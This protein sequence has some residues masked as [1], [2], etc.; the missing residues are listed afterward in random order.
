M[1]KKE[2]NKQYY[3]DHGKQWLKDLKKNVKFKNFKHYVKWQCDIPYIKQ[4][5]YKDIQFM[6]DF[7]DSY[8][9]GDFR[10]DVFDTIEFKQNYLIYLLDNEQEEFLKQY[11][12]ELKKKEI[13]EIDFSLIYLQRKVWR[14]NKREKKNHEY[15]YGENDYSIE[16]GELPNNIEINDFSMRDLSLDEFEQEFIFYTREKMLP[17]FFFRWIDYVLELEYLETDNKD[18]KKMRDLVKKNYEWYNSNKR[19]N[20]YSYYTYISFL[21]K[22]LIRELKVGENKHICE[23]IKMI[24]ENYIYN[25]NNLY[26][27]ELLR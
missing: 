11:E 16:A 22:L 13:S 24:F 26:L 20:K 12:K 23:K 4:L 21:N 3:E 6:Y 1:T 8:F 10:N 27:K 15:T 19:K 9:N 25:K 5:D 7:F 14:K 17:D 18:Y 2:Y